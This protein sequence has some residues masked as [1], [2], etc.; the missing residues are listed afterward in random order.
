M[1]YAHYVNRYDPDASLAADTIEIFETACS[2]VT[3]AAMVDWVEAEMKSREI[4]PAWTEENLCDR[5]NHKPGLSVMIRARMLLHLKIFFFYSNS[6]LS[7]LYI[8]FK[9]VQITI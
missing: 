6:F 8:C 2:G 3:S 5:M 7:R 4:W 9:I 1:I